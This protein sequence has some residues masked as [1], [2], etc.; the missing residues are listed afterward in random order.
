VL[1]KLG[2]SEDFWAY[3]PAAST[4][5]VGTFLE[6]GRVDTSLYTENRIDFTPSVTHGT[7][8]EIVLGSLLGLAGIAVLSL[9]W[10]AGR[11][12]RGA[13]FGPKGSVAARAVLPLVLGLGG[14]CLGVLVA[15]TALPTVPITDQVLAVLSV[16][17]PVAL[18][19]YA[20]WFRQPRTGMPAGVAAFAAL[21]TAALGA[22]LGFHV[23]T[24]PALGALT[25]IVGATA[26]ANL[27]LIALDA[28]APAQAR[29]PHAETLPGPA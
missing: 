23:P 13:S 9:L 26:A 19:V 29:S 1:P 24:V 22:W 25:A 18:A 11:L 8:A 2:H 6:S 17:P 15:L 16:A 27:G 14:W 21:T 20:G 4:R 12:R 5:L 7:I 3:E 10:I 28:T